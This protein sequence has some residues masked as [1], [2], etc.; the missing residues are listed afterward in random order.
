MKCE[1][2]QKWILQEDAGELAPGQR[3]LMERHVAGCT[4][5]RHFRFD[6][7]QIAETTVVMEQPAV[8][9]FA[10]QMLM[11]EARRVQARQAVPSLGKTIREFFQT[12]E[13]PPFALR[14]AAGTTAVVLLLAGTVVLIHHHN[15]ALRLAWDDGV[16]QQIEQLER[17]M[18]SL[19]QDADDSHANTSDEET[20]ASQLLAVEG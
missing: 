12:L 14:L 17:S 1:K 10:L 19:S 2:I 8:D 11:N 3:L 4:E 7:H 18:A 9:R 20:I 13:T 6:L 16:D 5:C 15:S